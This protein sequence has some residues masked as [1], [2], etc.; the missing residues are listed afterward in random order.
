MKNTIIK[1]TKLLENVL[2]AIFI[3]LVI[4]VLW[5]VITR[6]L[7]FPSSFTEELSRYLMIWLAILATAYSRSY[8]GQMAID[9]FYEK[10]N[11]KNKFRISLFIE[12]CIILFAVS[13]MIIGGINLMY[14]TLKLGQTSASLHLPM[15]LVYSVV[16]ISGFLILFFSVFHIKN[17]I[18]AYQF[19]QTKHF[20]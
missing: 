2:V 3:I 16:P 12:V 4:D 8:K 13:V 6:Y 14:I 20:N 15:G 9:F 10:L 1:T 11:L 17:Y 7:G 5:Q 18:A 19:S